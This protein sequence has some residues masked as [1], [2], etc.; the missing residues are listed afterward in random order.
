LPDLCYRFDVDGNAMRTMLDV[1]ARKGFLRRVDAPPSC[2]FGAC[3][4]CAAEPP[5]V[6]EWIGDGN[7]PG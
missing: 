2:G 7:P 6:Y 3:D 5:E 1:W 4:G